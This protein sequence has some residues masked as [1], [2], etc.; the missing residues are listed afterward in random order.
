VQ[1]ALMLPAFSF[2][3]DRFSQVRTAVFFMSLSNSWPCAQFLWGWHK[4][5]WCDFDCASSL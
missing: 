2:Y 4:K 1:I 5:H 3:G